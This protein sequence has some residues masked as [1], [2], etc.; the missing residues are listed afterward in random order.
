MKL[1]AVRCLGGPCTRLPVRLPR[2]RRELRFELTDGAVIERDL[3]E[4]RPKRRSSPT[5]KSTFAV[6]D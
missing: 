5:A 1:L 3:A 2:V 4:P 6:F